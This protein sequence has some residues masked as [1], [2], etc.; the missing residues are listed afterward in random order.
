MILLINAAST[1]FMTGL[2]WFVQIVHY[3]LFD[4]VGRDGFA[5]YERRHSG[6]TALI[7]GPVMIVELATAL[8]LVALRPGN[9]PGWAA[10]AGA[11]LVAAIW[12]ST[13]LLQIPEHGNL[14]SGFD[15][16]ALRRLIATN[17]LRT[18]AWSL[19]SGLV[20]WL[21]A[22]AYVPETLR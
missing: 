22:R 8:G 7:V 16:H 5:D 9:V 4:G 18:A 19:R 3:P 13:A 10:W 11:I 14:A 2:I 6:A 20:L 1:L 15:A 17:W 12:L 21:L